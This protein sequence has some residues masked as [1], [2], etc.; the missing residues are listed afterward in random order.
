MTYTSL[1]GA[2]GV[3][4]AIATWVDYTLL[5]IPPI[6]DEAQALIYS[7]L[8]CREMRSTFPFTLTVGQAYIPLPARFLDPIGR[9]QVSSFNA[10]IRN[11]DQNS[12]TGARNYTETAGTLGTDP[13]TTVLNSNSVNVALTAHGFAQELALLHDRR[14]GV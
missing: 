10:P 9:I 8:R 11:K 4:G 2:K 3:S 12:L 14:G 7:V 6:V 1:T 5:D 13:L